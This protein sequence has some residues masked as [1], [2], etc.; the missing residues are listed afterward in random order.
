[1]D[2]E[3]E[4]NGQISTKLLGSEKTGKFQSTVAGQKD[5]EVFETGEGGNG[6]TIHLEERKDLRREHQGQ[7][8]VHHVAFRV[9][10]ETE[11]HQWIKKIQD[12][13][14]PNSGFI[15][16]YYFRSFYF[17]ELNGV[18]FELA[19]DGPGFDRDEDIEHLGERLSLPPFLEKKR[20][21]IEANLKP[22]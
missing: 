18:L 11:L 13:D 5:I 8:G 1:T 14:L 19:T 2:P 22:L 6:A 3:R 10:D 17:R 16:R 4:L 20:E 9:K 15:N 7:G 12:Q 21:A